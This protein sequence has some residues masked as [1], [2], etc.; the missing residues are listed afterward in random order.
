MHKIFKMTRVKW[1]SSSEHH[2]VIAC[3]FIEQDNDIR[4]IVSEYLGEIL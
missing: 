4:V 2:Q 1:N 3:S